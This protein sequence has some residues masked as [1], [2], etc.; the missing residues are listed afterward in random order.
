MV[1]SP[2]APDP[3]K[4]AQ[5]QSGMNR[6]TAI[7]QQMVNMVNQVTPDGSLTY[8]QTGTGGFTDSSG[9]WV[10]VPQ[11]TSTQTLS[12]QQQAIKDQ[13]DAASLGLSKFANSQI[14]R[15][16][17]LLGTPFNLSG[18][19]GVDSWQ[20][21]GLPG[22]QQFADAPQ[23]ATSFGDAGAIN[24]NFATGFGDAGSINRNFRT[25]IDDAGDITT[26]YN[27]DF[28][29][30]RQRVEDALMARMQ[31]QLDRQ[32]RGIETTLA[33]QGIRLGSDAYS[34]GQADFGRQVNDAVL[35]NI[36]AAGQEQSR[37]VGMERD[38]AV[39]ENAAQA[40]QYGQNANDAA[41]Y[42][43]ALMAGNAAQQQNYDQLLGRAQFGH[44]G[45][46]L[47]NQAQQ[48]NYDQL[49]GRAT[50]GNAATQQNFANQFQVTGANNQLAQQ[51]FG[52]QMT[53]QQ[54]R[55]SAQ[56]QAQNAYLQQQFALRNQPINEITALLSGSQV[57]QP[58]FTNTP[59]TGV[60]GVDYTG[61]VNQQYQAE[62][63]NH[64]AKMG[65]I[66]G[67]LS[68][69]FGMFNFTS[70]RR[71]K[72]DIEPVGKLDNGLT[73]Y[74]Y[75]M[76]GDPRFQI[77]LMADEVEQIAPEAV[78]ERPDGFKTVNYLMATEA[79]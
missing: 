12:P 23:L 35:G 3:Y 52:N 59:Q 67:L 36:L 53:E 72:E 77:G 75:R 13:Q 54:A 11:Y 62:V 38:R 37:L 24:Q 40:Q 25:G 78:G 76:K 41:F 49:L 34:S 48:Q 39:F 73:V 28:S 47:G 69:P 50:F 66:F 18:M 45:Q 65:G 1:S 5:A 55:L 56:Q 33:N 64:Q 32:R 79:A 4:T 17:G 51:Q 61:L 68:A 43:Q 46:M 7:T 9:K 6:D 42:N 58:N 60:A 57:S 19:P 2:K 16:D 30:D 71:L 10:E 44:Q 15:L 31:P 74:R 27:G 26:S 70:D 63:A 14:D 8:E 29:E 22:F 20:Q 21:V